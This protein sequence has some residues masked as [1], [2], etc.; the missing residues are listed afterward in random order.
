MNSHTIDDTEVKRLA[1]LARVFVAP[2]E[3]AFFKKD[4]E[5]ILGFIDTIQE[6]T[7][8]EGELRSE[9]F[10]PVGYVRNDELTTVPGS[11]GAAVLVEAAPRHA[12]NA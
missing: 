8:P 11:A 5:S 7:V 6:V 2:E 10:A 4:I 3:E 12:D 1:N 9:G